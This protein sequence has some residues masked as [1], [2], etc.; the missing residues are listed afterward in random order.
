MHRL[1]FCVAL[2]GVAVGC[3]GLDERFA[4]KWSGSV[5]G[6][7]TPP[8]GQPIV[9]STNT[10]ITIE[11]VG[12]E[13]IWVVCADKSGRLPLEGVG[14]RATWK[15]IQSCANP[16]TDCPSGTGVFRDSTF[17]ITSSG[18]LNATTHVTL[19]ACGESAPAT[20]EF[21]GAK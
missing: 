9:I 20:Y 4:G 17:E 15:G 13:F 11:R 1:L 19:T 2:S 3:G 10:T 16:T 12:E 8:S 14:T 18:R 6:T 21:Q 5:V 7:L